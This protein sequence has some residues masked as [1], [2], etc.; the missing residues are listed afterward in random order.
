MSFLPF[1]LSFLL[2]LVLGS[3]VLFNSFRSTSLEKTI[4]LGVHNGKLNLIS[5]QHQT[6]FKNIE[7]KENDLNKPLKKTHREK[8]L[9]G[10][11]YRNRRCER[12]NL[13][14]SK[15]NLWPLFKGE[16]VSLSAILYDSAVELIKI[17][18]KD[19]DFYKDENDKGLAKA[20]VDE[21]LKKKGES[22]SE[23]SPRDERLAA[24]Y[25]KMLKGTNTSY[26]A[27][28]EYFSLEKTNKKP[29]IWR[30][31]SAPVLEAILGADALKLI[32]TTEKTFWE[33]NH[34]KAALSKEELKKP[35]QECSSNA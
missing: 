30:Y 4:I 11:V 27:L 6:T 18:Y 33:A 2:I 15:L 34:Y 12:N 25:Y 19:A 28:E 3:S 31:A 17:L 29:V 7:K 9:P 1:V 26:P 32:L 13:E 35:A 16:D 20:I 10:K 14:T 8:A 24:I 22:F 21:M 5:Q 23:L